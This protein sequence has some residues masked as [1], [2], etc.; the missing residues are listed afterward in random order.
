VKRIGLLL[1][2]ATTACAQAS[3][4]GSDWVCGIAQEPTGDL[5][6]DIAGLWLERAGATTTAWEIHV[7]GTA[8][9]DYLNHAT[10][11]RAEQAW[12]WQVEAGA[13]VLVG[14]DAETRFVMQLDDGGWGRSGVDSFQR[15]LP[16]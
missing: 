15:C 6:R 16:T 7:D 8:V 11:T 10:G 9:S 1:L 13:V 14:A 5:E 3:D 12:T 4:P 2:M